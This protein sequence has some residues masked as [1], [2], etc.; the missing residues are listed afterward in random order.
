MTNIIITNLVVVTNTITNFIT[1]T[2]SITS[3]SDPSLWTSTIGGIFT[4]I[5][6]SITIWIAHRGIKN[7]EIDTVHRL[8][9]SYIDTRNQWF[10][11]KD[12]KLK[13][14]LQ[15]DMCNI[16]EKMSNLV[17]YKFMDEKLALMSFERTLI[18]SFEHG[19][20]DF[21]EINNYAYKD[22]R[23]LYARWKKINPHITIDNIKKAEQQGK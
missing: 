19:D 14:R 1:E 18:Q 3:W 21:Y 11:S 8:R 12:K 23:R 7:W 13:K 9:Q 17:I 4:I 20:K 6:T 5:L 15:V 10:E 16:L 22:A 2:N